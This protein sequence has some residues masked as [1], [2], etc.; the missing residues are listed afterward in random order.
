MIKSTAESETT[1]A[2]DTEFT[3][4]KPWVWKTPKPKSKNDKPEPYEFLS[5]PEWD[6][7][8]DAVA[9]ALRGM[10]FV[11]AP[12]LFEGYSYRKMAGGALRRRMIGKYSKEE[13]LAELKLRD[14]RSEAE[15]SEFE[16]ELNDK[17]AQYRGKG[18]QFPEV[19]VCPGIVYYP[20]D[21]SFSFTE[22]T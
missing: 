3:D 17:I 19:E 2:T 1:E 22:K 15:R 18:K 14:P 9:E 8:P 12:L 6:V 5:Y 11:D 4:H 16:K 10:G 13:L 7:L 21:G 20:K